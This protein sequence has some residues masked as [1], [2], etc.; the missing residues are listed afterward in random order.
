MCIFSNQTQF[1]II[2][3][4]F[5]YYL[6]CTRNLKITPAIHFCSTAITIPSTWTARTSTTTYKTTH[7]QMTPPH[8]GCCNHI[9]FIRTSVKNAAWNWP[10]WPE[11][12]LV[13]T[14]AF[15]MSVFWKV[16]SWRYKVSSL[17]RLIEQSKRSITLC[18]LLS[19]TCCKKCV[20]LMDYSSKSFLFISLLR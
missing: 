3:N 11:T 10:T 4:G 9:R 17:Y 20:W 15:P 1:P 12:M 8:G 19:D 16:S 13:C 5:L 7:Q 2:K 6:I 18:V 14:D